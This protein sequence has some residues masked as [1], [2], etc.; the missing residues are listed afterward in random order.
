MGFCLY[1]NVAVAALELIEQQQLKRVAIFDWD[2]HHGNGTE[3]ILYD[4]ADVMY[5]STHQYPFYP[6]TGAVSDVGRGDGSGFTINAPMPAG[7]GDADYY[8]V[9]DRVIIPLLEDFDPELIIVSA[10][11]DAHE[12]DPLADMRL[13]SE[14]YH[15]FTDRLSGLGPPLALVLEGGYDPTGL[16]QGVRESLLAI[17]EPKEVDTGLVAHGSVGE[18]V[19]ARMRTELTDYWSF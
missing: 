2:V 9:L 7:C 15:L 8:A 11:Y 1:S 16:A 3:E 17:A 18:Q 10:G 19:A 5:I 13:T 14:A 4:R 12:L 6:G